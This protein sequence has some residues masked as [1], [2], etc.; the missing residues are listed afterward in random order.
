MLIAHI[1]DTHI[2]GEG[3]KAYGI[4]PMADN[5]ARCI[6]HINSFQPAPDVVLMTGD[7]GNAGNDQEMQQ[8]GALLAKL[9][10]PVYMVPGNHDDRAVMRSAFG[11]GACPVRDDGFINYVVDD[12]DVR[13][14]GLDSTSAGKPGG[15]FCLIRAA[16]LDEQLASDSQKPTIIFMHHPPVKCSVPETDEDGFAGVEHLAGVVKKYDNIERILCGHIHLVTHTRWHGTII[17][18]AP[19]MGMQLELDLTMTNLSKFH[20][21]SPAYLL[22]HWTGQ[23]NLI[24]HSIDVQ[25]IDG[26]YLFEEQIEFGTN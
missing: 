3:K 7:L 22:H 23:N 25:D 9:N 6:A 13:L 8:A 11:N 2:A 16:W 26:P 1:S 20:L 10:C 24:T 19:S 21:T 5:L 18:S 4:A 12:Y 15:E 17:S 14:I